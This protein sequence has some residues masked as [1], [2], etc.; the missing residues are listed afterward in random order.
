VTEKTSKGD[1]DGIEGGIGTLLTTNS[2]VKITLD[3]PFTNTI[4]P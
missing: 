4:I 1:R 3:Q 2:S